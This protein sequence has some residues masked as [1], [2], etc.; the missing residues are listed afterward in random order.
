MYAKKNPIKNTPRLTKY[1]LRL[2]LRP[3]IQASL[4]LGSI[5]QGASLFFQSIKPLSDNIAAE[6]AKT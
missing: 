4:N 6:K 3:L 5:G 1:K 2:V